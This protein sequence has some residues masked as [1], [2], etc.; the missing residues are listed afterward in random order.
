MQKLTAIVKASLWQKE[1]K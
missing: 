1:N